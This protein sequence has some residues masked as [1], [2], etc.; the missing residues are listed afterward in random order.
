VT[1]LARLKITD[2]DSGFKS[3]T[4]NIKELNRKNIKIGIFGKD[5]SFQV[6]KA[7]VHEFGAKIKVTPKMRAWFHYKGFHLNPST[8]EIVIPER[9]FIRKT[10]DQK[11]R[12]IEELTEEQIANIFA[13]KTN[14]KF[15]LKLMAEDLI[16]M[17]RKTM[18]DVDTPPLSGMTKKMRRGSGDYNPLVDDGRMRQSVTHQID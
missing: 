17:V 15:A 4:M 14:A 6:M 5:D 9:S 1:Y 8:K 7:S 12:K 11:G 13:Q 18:T 10:F 3:I 2:D 16:G